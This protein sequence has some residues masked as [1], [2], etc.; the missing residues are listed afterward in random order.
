MVQVVAAL[1]R[2]GE[3]FLVCQRPAHKARGLLWEFVGGKVE[4]GETRQQALVRECREELDITVEPGGIF[5]ELDHEYPDLTIH[6]T[7]FDAVIAEGEP[8]LLEH[9]ALAWI[10]TDEIDTLAFC[11]ADAQI[12]EALKT[13]RPTV[14]ARL[15]AMQDEKYR[16]FTAPL[17][18]TLKRETMIGVRIPRIRALAK[19]MESAEEAEAFLSRLPHTWFEENILHAA[20]LSGIKSYEKTAA[21]LDAFLPY[22][23]NW[24]VCDTLI[25]RAFKACPPQLPEKVRA[26]LSSD[27]P[28]TVRFGLGTLMRF[29]LDDAFRPE[30]LE[31]AADLRSEEYYVNMMI[32]WYFA[33]ALAKQYD[34]AIVFFE[35]KRLMSWTHNKAIQ[36][37]VESYRVTPEHKTYLKT[38]KIRE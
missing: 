12:L 23:D 7:L 2:D 18:P 21:A 36:K 27:A 6:L 8:K 10:T 13:R 19:E 31:W 30:Y 5:M 29:Y 22:V 28:Y 37:A 15:F 3:R 17:L 38:L 9:A 33:T 14:Q 34:A 4:A 1:I 32:A 25:P 20:L 26:W 16:D 11:P 24:S 35:E